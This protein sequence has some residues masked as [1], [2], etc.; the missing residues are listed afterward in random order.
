MVSDMKPLKVGIMSREA[1]QK[2]VIAIASGRYKPKRGEPKIW[3]H[4]LKSLSE[5]LSENNVELL[6]MM[7]AQQ[8]QSVSQLAQMSGR[9]QSNLSRTLNTMAQYGLVE[10]RKRDKAVQ[11]VARAVNFDIVY[12][13][14]A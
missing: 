9:S 4:S 11:P 10:M 1:Y 6:Q 14:Q 3:F 2:R 5:V 8:P 13:T 12:H 7:S